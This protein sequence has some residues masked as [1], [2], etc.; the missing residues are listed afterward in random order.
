MKRTQDITNNKNSNQRQDIEVKILKIA[1]NKDN[2]ISIKF[3]RPFGFEYFV[4]NYGIA[5]E[6]LDET[7]KPIVLPI[8][9]Y[10]EEFDQD[11]LTYKL[12]PPVQLDSKK[13]VHRIFVMAIAGRQSTIMPHVEIIN[14][15]D[16]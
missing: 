3:N 8:G 1:W 15:R 2:T 7:K 10:K 14:E 5:Y 6:L 16:N 9:L 12:S 4:N 11:N 13:P